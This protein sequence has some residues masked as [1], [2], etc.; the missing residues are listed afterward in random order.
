MADPFSVAASAITLIGISSNCAKCL[1][2]LIQ[3]LRYAPAELQALSNEVNDLKVVLHQIRD[4]CR[5]VEE[6]STPA[7]GFLSTA[8]EQ[9]GNATE[10]LTELE[11][12]LPELPAKKV[13][14]RWKWERRR[15]RA[16][17]LLGKLQDIKSNLTGLL[18]LSS[19]IAT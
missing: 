14:G 4:V 6:D 19:A 16:K 13:S 11:R 18:A 9:L 8:G 10:I 5:L 3:H 2:D 7:M 15:P 12:L 17:I 1:F